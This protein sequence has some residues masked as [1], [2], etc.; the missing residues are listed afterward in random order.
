MLALQALKQAD[1]REAE[2]A[3]HRT[4]QE[5]RI[6]HTLER[7]GGW[8]GLGW[9]S[10]GLHLAAS[11]TTGAAVWDPV[12]GKLLYVK[13]IKEGM[14]NRLAFSP[15][16]SLLV[17]PSE[18]GDPT[19]K[20]YVSI[21][22][23]KTGQDLV[24]FA[25]HD[26][27]VQH[28]SFNPAGTQ[29]VTASGDG[30]IKIWDLTKTL[31]SGEGQSIL[32]VTF[33]KGTTPWAA[34]FSPDGKHL[35]TA[36]DDLKI[37]FLDAKSGKELW[38]APTDSYDLSF[39]PNGGRMVVS[40]S[41]GMLDVLDTSTGKR[42][43]RT[44][45]GTLNIE[46]LLFNRDGTRLATASK[47]GMVKIWAFSEDALSPLLTL[48]GHKD[49][50]ASLAFSPDGGQLASGGGALDGTIRIWDISPKGSVEPIIYQHLAS[51]QSVAFSPDGTQLAT[52]GEDGRAIIWDTLGGQSLHILSGQDWIWRVAYNPGGD[53]L[54]TASRDATLKLW[55]VASGTEISTLTGH[56]GRPDS[57]FLKASCLQP[58]ARTA[59]VWRLREG[60]A[61][62]G[63]GKWQLCARLILA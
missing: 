6:I 32:T 11:G 50:V 40:G 3:L 47:D 46:S 18:G 7:P 9:S 8:I 48:S 17:L 55:D 28:A 38:Q 24:T 10:D 59:S 22:D 58:S 52:S 62:C 39:S 14:I 29:F 34:W 5:L 63:S 56:E 12:S 19:A 41:M 44:F 51:V 33:S 61:R 42:L 1:T 30:T 43:S 60:M 15:D 23:A 20:C 54:A 36:N 31:A 53:L 21:L 4:V 25:A 37:H 35:A 16:G 27:Y 49:K 26:A 45:G 13:E 57:Y 2:E